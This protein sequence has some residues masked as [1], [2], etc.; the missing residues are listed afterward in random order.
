M[1]I[2]L[3]GANGFVG[4][5]LRKRFPDHVII[6]RNDESGTIVKKLEDV[7]VVI[8]LAGAPIIKRWSEPYKKTLI[9]SR[10]HTTRQLV[11]AIN[12]SG[13]SHFISTS[14]IG[15]YPDNRSCDEQCTE[16]ADDFLGHLATTWEKEAHKCNKPTTILRFGVVLGPDGGALK[17]MLTPFRMGVGGIIGNG[18]M[19]TSW[20]DLEDLLRMYEFVIDKRLQGTYNATAPH[21]VTNYTFTKALGSV[22]HRPTF[23]PV[24]V[25]ALKIMYGE[26]ASVL[27]GSK[28]VYPKAITDAGF[29]F[30]YSEIGASLRH[31]LDATS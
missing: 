4:T 21:P 3:T 9:D 19:M 24:P 31:L 30:S 13:V 11:H 23:L 14:A 10:I 25:F 26:G 16:V 6:H 5:A 20:I 22:L 27:T 7:D 1:K 18:R 28:E 17:T 12:Q 15:I 8:N 2:A 29:K